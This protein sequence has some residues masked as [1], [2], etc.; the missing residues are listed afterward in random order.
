MSMK[1][2]RETEIVIDKVEVGACSF[3]IRGLSPMIY[4]AMSSKARHQLLFPNKKTA[5]EKNQTMKHEPEEEFRNS[6]YR[7]KAEVDYDRGVRIAA[8]A[9]KEIENS[10]YPTRLCFPAGGIKKALMSAALEVPGAKKA[11]IGRL[12]WVEGQD[13]PV[14][15]VPELFMAVTRSSDIGRTPDVRTRA[16]LPEWCCCVTIKYV[17]PTLNATALSRLLETAGLVIGLGDFR[18]EKGAGNYGQFSIVD[19]K[20]CADLIKSGGRKAQ[21]AAL[22]SPVTYDVESEKLL[23]WFNEERIARGK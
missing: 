8:R 9:K 6:V 20:D 12:V 21:D 16:I 22:A 11:Q 18:Q 23:T 15:G 5:A 19:E 2:K 3:W 13:V 4:N 10:Q 17:Q 1:A 7:N 14:Y